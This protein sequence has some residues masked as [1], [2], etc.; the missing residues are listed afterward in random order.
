MKKWVC[1]VKK[2]EKIS[3]NKFFFRIFKFLALFTPNTPVFQLII[4]IQ[5]FFDNCL[6]QWVFVRRS[7]LAHFW[8]PI[9]AFHTKKI[10]LL[11]T[12]AAKS[13]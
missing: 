13:Q 1:E 11:D 8:I 5:V 3:K 12:D 4:K 7:T 6:V 9:G 10:K 2:T